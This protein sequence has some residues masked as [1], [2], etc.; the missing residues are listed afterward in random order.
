MSVN[1]TYTRSGDGRRITD[2]ASRVGASRFFEL[3]YGLPI[4]AIGLSLDGCVYAANPAAEAL[5][6]LGPEQI[7]ERTLGDIPTFAASAEELA[8]LQ[9]GETLRVTLRSAAGS[10]RVCDCSVVALSGSEP[11]VSGRALLFQDQTARVRLERQVERE[12]ERLRWLRTVHD[13]AINGVIITDADQH[14]LFA[15]K[16]V[17]R[18]TGY[19]FEEMAGKRPRELFQGPDTDADEL[20]RVR[21]AIRSRLPVQA[22]LINYTRDGKPYWVEVAISPV[23]DDQGELTHFV[24]FQNDISERKAHEATILRQ[25]EELARAAAQLER[26]SLT[27]SVTG[28]KNH[29][30]FQESLSEEMSAAACS[31]SPLS[32]A[33]LDID[34][35]KNYNDRHGHLEGDQALRIVAD[36]MNETLRAADIVCRYGGEEFVVIMPGVGEEAAGAVAERVRAAIADYNWP[37]TPLTVSIGVATLRDEAEQGRALILRADQALYAAKRSGRNRSVNSGSAAA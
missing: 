13:S 31:G 29:R 20:K 4:A 24:S 5:L 22:E 34:G 18:L 15:N 12:A 3:F 17:E 23:F 30:A 26:L 36:L 32:L 28:L 21:G 25:R 10:E 7:F 1:E 35:F 8:N 27:D 9:P 33:M 19:T 37:L 16:A 2:E 6:G 14:I 11:G